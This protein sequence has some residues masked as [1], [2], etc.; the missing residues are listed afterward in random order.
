[1]LIIIGGINYIGKL[2]L[3]IVVIQAS[4]LFEMPHWSLAGCDWI[5]YGLSI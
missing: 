3:G 5:G 4:F 1:M 2:G